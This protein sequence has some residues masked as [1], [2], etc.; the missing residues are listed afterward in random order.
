MLLV[1]VKS[2]TDTVVRPDVVTDP[3]RNTDPLIGIETVVEPTK[4]PD[5]DPL[6]PET[7]T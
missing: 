7:S 5:P 6:D 3:D 1:A 4:E 2:P